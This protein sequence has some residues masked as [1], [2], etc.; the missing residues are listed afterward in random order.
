MHIHDQGVVHVHAAAARAKEH[1][2]A[3]GGVGVVGSCL[4]IATFC[5]TAT[6][7]LLH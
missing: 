6:L 5:A 3:S 4:P 1:T 2:A 7:L